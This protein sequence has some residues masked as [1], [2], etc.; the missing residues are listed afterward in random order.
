MELGLSFQKYDYLDVLSERRIYD[1]D[2]P[3]R[4]EWEENLLAKIDESM[5]SYFARIDFETLDSRYFTRRGTAVSLDFELCTDNLYQWRGG[6][7]FSA[8]SLSWITAIP[9]S[10]RFSLIPSA[11]GRVLSGS[12][13]PFPMVNMVGGKY[14]GRY[15]SQQMPFD[16][17]EYMETTPNIFLAAKIQGRQMIGRRHFVSGSFNYG[18]AADDFLSLS[19]EGRNYFGASLNYGYDLRNFPLQV[20]LSW[21]NITRNVGFYFQAGY[22]F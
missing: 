6:A 5:W 12:G 14:F 1:P 18:I 13:I 15:M 22:M 7:P 11:Y 17:I 16:G 9:M 10:E 4:P 8:L 20:S 21:S 3:D 19:A 2:A